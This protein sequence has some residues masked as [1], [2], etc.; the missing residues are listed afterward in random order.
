[1]Y[2]WIAHV[3]GWGLPALFLAISLPVTGVSFRVGGACIPNPKD[4]FATWFG[5]LIAFGVLGALIQFGT[6]GFCLAIY[7]KSWFRQDTQSFST[8]TGTSATT[9]GSA[10]VTGNGKQSARKAAKRLA[11][12]RVRKVLLMQWR[13]IALS[14]LVIFVTIYFGVIYARQVTTAKMSSRPEHSDQIYRWT[15]CLIESLGDKEKCMPLAAALSVPEG[16]VIAS[17]FL[18]SVSTI[19]GCVWWCIQKR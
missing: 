18:I 6:T 1:L 15:V 3:L 14:V 5:W 11:W 8:T 12:R 2:V 19:C 17:F 16:T 10:G 7:M 4:A 9:A 13:S